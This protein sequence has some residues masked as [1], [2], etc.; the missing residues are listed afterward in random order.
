MKPFFNYSQLLPQ[1]YLSISL[2]IS[3]I[4]AR[5]SQKQISIIV[6]HCF[7]EMENFLL[8]SRVP[9]ISLVSV[10]LR[11]DGTKSCRAV[12]LPS[13]KKLPKISKGINP[14]HTSCHN[15]Y[16]TLRGIERDLFFLQNPTKVKMFAYKNGRSSV[17]RFDAPPP[18]LSFSQMEHPCLCRMYS[19]VTQRVDIRW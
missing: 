8:F 17:L 13:S 2:S 15:L 4:W 3:Q 12:Q 18:S 1:L 9:H 14:S 7:P 19:S 16:E 11:S 6:G 10:S 5:A